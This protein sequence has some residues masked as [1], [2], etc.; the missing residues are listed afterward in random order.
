MVY[1]PQ[2]FKDKHFHKIAFGTFAVEAQFSTPKINVE[3]SLTISESVANALKYPFFDGTLHVFAH[4][5]ILY[6]GPLVGIFTSGFTPYE[7]RP[8]GERTSF[9][10]K[11]LSVHK[12]VGALVF[13]FGEQH[14]NWE[15]GTISGLFL[16]QNEWKTIEVPFPN[17]IYDRLPNRRSEK[18]SNFKKVKEK[19]QDEYLIPWYNP[20]FFNKLDVFER[21]TGDESVAHYLP[22]TFPLTSISL[23]ERLLS[24]YGQVFVKPINGSLGLGVH[25]IIFDKEKGV[26]YCRY[27][28]QEYQNKLFKFSS[29]ESLFNFVFK[30]RNL[31]HFLVQQGVKLIKTENRLLDFR[32]HTNKDDNGNWQVS[33]IAAKLAGVGSVTTHINNGGSIKSIDEIFPLIDEKEEVIQKLSE[34]ALHLS[35]SLENQMEGIIGEIGFDMGIDRTGKVWLFEANSKPGRSI[36]KHPNLKKFDYLTRRLSLAF[37]VFL[38]KQSIEHPEEILK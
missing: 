30:K 26:Y 9:F 31:S 22:E 34:A 33:A 2:E 14:I 7:Q 3:N 6:I 25:Q 12:S 35:Q 18:R 24:D 4:E 8:I 32:V 19:L 1:L 23:V 36:F 21:L 38:T 28:N 27:R 16:L 37:A 13:V 20:G 10:T 15:Q 29:L 11:L 5:N 17:V